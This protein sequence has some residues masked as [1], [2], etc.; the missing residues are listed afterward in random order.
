M[1]AGSWLPHIDNVTAHYGIVAKHIL[2][3][4]EW[5]TLVRPDRPLWIQDK[6]PLTIWL[7]ALSLRVFGDSHFALRFWHVLMTL[8]LVYVTYRFARLHAG[9]ETSLLAALLLAT[10][11]AVFH[12]TNAP[13]QDVPLTLFLAL[14]F[15][16]YVTYRTHGRPA[17]ALLCALWVALGVLSK[18]LVMVVAFGP[19][20]V[21]DLLIAWRRHEDVHSQWPHVALAAALFL[22]VA[23]PWFVAGALRQGAPFVRAF[24]IG[25]AGVGRF[26]HRFL[27]PGIGPRLGPLTQLFGYVPLLIVGMLP[28]AGLLP[29][30]VQKARL[31]LVEGPP[32]VRVLTLYGGVL[33]LVLSISQGDKVLRYLLPCFPP[34]AVLAAR[35]LEETID[36]PRGLRPAAWITLLAG[37]LL[38]VASVWLTGAQTTGIARVYLR[39]VTPS[40]VVFGAALVTFAIWIHRGRGRQAVALLAVGAL[41]S[42]GLMGW[43]I[44]R[45][46]ERL[47][48]WRDIGA[49]VS[50]LYHDGDRV[51][52][53]S[54]PEAD[55]DFLA[56]YITPAVQSVK[57][58]DELLTAWAEGRVFGLISP[59]SYARL[60]QRLHATVLI[61]T[62]L[63]WRLVINR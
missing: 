62:P 42:Y 36:D 60:E 9:R 24:T 25:E 20:L 48:P 7:I 37:I 46:W 30:V 19:A 1:L 22:L 44:D 61:Q 2:T 5:I 3:T 32:S 11:L 49:M 29:G 43:A 35:A 39:L 41:V 14:A 33:F 16:S 59:E 58:D 63:G 4:S 52:M 23:L 38:L 54:G 17:A 56:Y 21:V 45:N 26:L 34:L 10:S 40:L 50:R 28:W 13:Q 53:L 6:P 51:V 18:G 57:T 55:P 8:A 27:G 15:Y 31:S 12:L 47:W